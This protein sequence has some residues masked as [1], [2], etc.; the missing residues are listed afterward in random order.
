VTEPTSIAEA[1]GIA[2]IGPGDVIAGKYRIDEVLGAGG[3]GVVFL[4]RHTL[5]NGPIALKFL[6]RDFVGNAQAVSRFHREAQAAARL[7]SENV[8]RV[9]DVGVHESGSPFIV[10]EHLEGGDLGRLLRSEGRLPVERAVDLML[11]ACSAMA[12]AHRE[13]IVHRDLKP[14]NLFCVPR[15]GGRFTLK[16]VDF[17]ISKLAS[18][19]QSMTVTGNFIGSPAYMSPEQMDAPNR[20]DERA[21]IWSLGV[22]LYECVTGKLPFSASSY[23]EIC[24]SVTQKSPV[25]PREH[26]GDLPPALERVILKCLEKDRE[27]RFASALELAGALREFAGPASDF[28]PESAGTT[29]AAT[30]FSASNRPLRR[31]PLLPSFSLTQPSWVRSDRPTSDRRPAL[32]VGAAVV[33]AAALAGLIVWSFSRDTSAPHAAGPGGA[34]ARAAVN[35]SSPVSPPTPPRV[36]PTP[37]RVEV[38]VRP[39]ATPS[40]ALPTPSVRVLPSAGAAASVAPRPTT[41]PAPAANARPAG[42]S[43]KP[44]SS[45]SLEAAPRPRPAPVKPP[46]DRDAKSPTWTR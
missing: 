25:R 18:A 7:K 45:A 36:T 34:S 8:V 9:F 11:Q 40:I 6:S 26:R 33:G 37:P 39:L 43:A 32:R 42:S 5:L 28:P 13:G 44:V 15:A 30:V 4:A 16:I 46:A 22:V 27:K 31:A 14:S 10:M 38:A 1:R 41:V 19:D 3:M 35:A 20:V 12:E 17:G 2:G 24:L 21:D 29:S 23:P